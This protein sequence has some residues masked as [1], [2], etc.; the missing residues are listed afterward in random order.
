MQR[1]LANQRKQLVR[2]KHSLKKKE[3]KCNEKKAL[4]TLRELLPKQIV[5]F[6]EMQ[7]K[8]HKKKGKGRRYSPEIKSF[9]LSLYH[10]SGRAYRLLSKFFYLPSKRSLR[11]WVSRLP[12]TPGITEAAMN[13]IETKVK[14]MNSISKICSICID[15]MSLKT[16]LI[17]DIS[18]DEILGFVD[19]GASK[20]CELIATSALVVMACGMADK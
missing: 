1:K 4:S 9:S 17:Y 16:N 7:L 2:L 19:L 5:D 11:R 12:R 10:V 3:E 8:L 18:A 14:V 15:E 20:K 13:V 6:I